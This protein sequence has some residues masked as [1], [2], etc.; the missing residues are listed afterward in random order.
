MESE[1]GRYLWYHFQLSEQ[2]NCVA[3][4]A[5]A[6]V[7][8][9]HP[10]AYSGGGHL[11]G[12][13]GIC[14]RGPHGES[15]GSETTRNTQRGPVLRH[16]RPVSLTS[17]VCKVMEAMVLARLEWTARALDYLVHCSIYAEDGAL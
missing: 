5:V 3:A 6:T 2:F 14:S 10:S 11:L 12:R 1:L 7:W 9:K 13:H 8:A 15:I 4:S 16:I 17:V